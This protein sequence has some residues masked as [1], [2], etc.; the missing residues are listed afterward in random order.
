MSNGQYNSLITLRPFV[1]ADFAQLMAWS[2]DEEQLM[3]YAG[4]SFS[5]PLTEA[6]LM[7]SLNSNDRK[8]FTACFAATG[9]Q[10]GH[11]EIYFPNTQTAHLCRLLVGD[12][13]HRGMGIGWA[14][15][16]GLLFIAFSMKGIELASLNV[17]D[18][19]LGAIRCYEKAGFSICP[20][21][22]MQRQ[23]KEKM[24][25]TLHMRLTK[26][27]WQQLNGAAALLH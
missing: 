11:G 7:A 6:Q 4:P 25:T 9:E 12:S 3:Q 26:E 21:K 8:A 17:Y 14:M 22:T 18:W 23:M 27:K 20:D 19:N 13:Q 10:A 15:V 5:Y 2:S 16:Q 1:E 24:W